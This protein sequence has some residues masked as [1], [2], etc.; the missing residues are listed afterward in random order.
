MRLFK[1][2]R[3]VSYS[4]A[5]V[6]VAYHQ[7]QILKKCRTGRRV[8]LRRQPRNPH[9][10]NAIEVRCGGRRI[11]YIRRSRSKEMV[12]SMLRGDIYRAQIDELLPSTDEMPL[13]GVR[14]LVTRWAKAD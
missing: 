10:E 7:R 3:A 8:R 13:V 1:H 4:L 12:A 5:I 2:R 6:G 9:D 14:I 11:G